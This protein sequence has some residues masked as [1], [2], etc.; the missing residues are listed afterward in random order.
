MTT[1]YQ[2]LIRNL[3]ETGPAAV[4]F[5]GGTDSA[6]LLYAAREALDGRTMAISV[7]TPYMVQREIDEAEALTR[8]W[9]IPHVVVDLD[10][11]ENIQYNPPDRCYLCKHQLFGTI[12]DTASKHGYHTLLEG[13]NRD[14]QYDHRPGR[15]ALEEM[16]VR[17][18]LLEAGLGKQEIRK[19]AREFRIPVWDKP[20][21]ACLLTRLPHGERVDPE[22]LRRIEGAEAALQEL[23]FRSVR[24]RVHG[25]L[26]RLEVPGDEIEKLAGAKQRSRVVEAVR[27]NGFSYVTLDLEGYRMGSFNETGRK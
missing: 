8:L 25:E 21:S 13:T 12:L 19:L 18:P 24:V 6:L 23:G 22:T 11:P 10:T 27:Q 2:K 4:A 3:Q 17:S 7:R 16:K 1:E 20:A 14:D 5:S 9:Q 15:K 26:V